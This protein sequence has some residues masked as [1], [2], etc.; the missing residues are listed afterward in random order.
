MILLRSL[1]LARSLV[2]FTC[3]SFPN[4]TVSQKKLHATVKFFV[5]NKLS[6][7]S[8]SSFWKR[9]QNQMKRGKRKHFEISPTLFFW[10]LITIIQLISGLIFPSHS[11]S[12]SFWIP[13]HYWWCMAF[14]RCLLL[15]LISCVLLLFFSFLLPVPIWFCSVLWQRRRDDSEYHN[16]SPKI[17][18]LMLPSF[19]H[20][21][22][23]SYFVMDI[24]PE[25]PQQQ[26]VYSH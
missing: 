24:T 3:T 19:H 20:S 2:L 18:V 14:L 16:K 10:L 1:S 25:T 17:N 7:F 15:L 26:H 21:I 9:K 5:R 13:Y 6:F 8:N 22:F 11:L 4:W 23:V 12:L